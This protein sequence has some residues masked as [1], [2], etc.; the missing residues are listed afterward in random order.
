MERQQKEGLL[1]TQ[2]WTLGHSL[3]LIVKDA[4]S[5]FRVPV[6][7]YARL[8]KGAA[9]TQACPSEKRDPGE[10]ANVQLKD[11]SGPELKSEEGTILKD[12]V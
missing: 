5:L 11:G 8:R 9:T 1:G 10:N 2:Y 6:Q 4:H 3:L 12:L 7:N